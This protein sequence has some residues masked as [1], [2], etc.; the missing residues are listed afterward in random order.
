M[1]EVLAQGVQEIA[2]SMV[3]ESKQALRGAQRESEAYVE[4]V[5]SIKTD[6]LMNPIVVC[7]RADA[8]T[9]E[10]Y[11]E[12]VDG[13]QR[14]NAVLDCGLETIPAN[15]ISNENEAALL[16]KQIVGNIHRI[17]TKPVEYSKHL[18][19]ILAL[20]PL[21]TVSVLASQLNKSSAWISQRLGLLN[22]DKKVAELVDD[23]KINLSN[24]YALAKL[25]V[26][27]QTNFIDQAMT[28]TPS[29]FVPKMGER[30]KELDKARREGRAASPA[31]FVPIPR[32]QKLAEAKAEVDKPAIAQLLV[33]QEGITDPVEAFTLG[34]K[35]S[36]HLDPMSVAEGRRQWESKQAA[37]N[38]KK[39]KAKADRLERRAKDAEVRSAR[40]KLETELVKAGKTEAEVKETLAAFDAEHGLVKEAQ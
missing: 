17:E 2:V 15:V 39:E 26:E 40:I 6:G 38:E 27:E 21:L 24:A 20:D 32:F 14:F 23:G 12:L 5:G 9:G 16:R 1:S 18:Q 29:E 25:P 3:R 28:E 8:G 10:Q 13:V 11:Y 30:K 33:N 34:V 36:L 7:V 4:L 35:W 22:L 37:I 19:K 31:D